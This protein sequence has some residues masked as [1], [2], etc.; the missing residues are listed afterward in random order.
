MFLFEA[1]VLLIATAYLCANSENQW[2]DLLCRRSVTDDV[3]AP[4]ALEAMVR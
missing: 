2:T 3:M 4:T 1:H